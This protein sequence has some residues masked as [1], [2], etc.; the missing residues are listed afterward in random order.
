MAIPPA[1]SI[2]THLM[3]STW[4][5]RHAR[6]EFDSAAGALRLACPALV[7]PG[8]LGLNDAHRRRRR[9][10]MT[11]RIMIDPKTLDA[12]VTKIAEGLPA[13]FGQLHEDLRNN[14]HA[15]VSAALAR[16]DLVTR[17][18]FD[19]QSAVLARTREKLTALEAKVSA[20]ERGPGEHPA[21]A[22]PDRQR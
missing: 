7:L 17:E 10:H 4:H 22:N 13:G 16:M 3:G 18:E 19:V 14:L 20:L 9:A 15:A 21:P 11:T 8:K 5:F 2:C 12:L 6:Q 1:V